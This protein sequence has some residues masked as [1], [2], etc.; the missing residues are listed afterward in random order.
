M[1]SG[2]V[3]SAR[4]NNNKDNASLGVAPLRAL[5]TKSIHSRGMWYAACGMRHGA[6]CSCWPVGPLPHWPVACCPLIRP[7]NGPTFNATSF[8]TCRA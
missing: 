5:N 2:P 4:C 7:G 3:A 6:C 8:C 1:G